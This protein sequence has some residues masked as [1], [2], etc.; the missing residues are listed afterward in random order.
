[1]NAVKTVEVRRHPWVALSVAVVCVA[2]ILWAVALQQ[3]G[4]ATQ[5]PGRADIARD[6]PRHSAAGSPSPVEP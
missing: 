1:M 4:Y 2:A 6:V 3:G 5:V